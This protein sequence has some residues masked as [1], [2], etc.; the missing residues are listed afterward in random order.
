MRC[1]N[2]KALIELINDFKND[3]VTESKYINTMLSSIAFSL[4]QIADVMLDNKEV[5]NDQ[6]KID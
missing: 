4:A 6:I 5:E 1:D 3:G 2:M